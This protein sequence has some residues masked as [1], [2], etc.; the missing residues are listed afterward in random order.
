MS[1]RV[2]SAVALLLAAWPLYADD[3]TGA[4]TFLCS[5]VQATECKADGECSS[6]PPWN[7][8]FPQFLEIDLKKGLMATTQAS[9]ENRSTPILS[10][11]RAEGR[12]LLQG[13]QLGRAFSM[14][15]TEQTGVAA[16][17]IAAEGMTVTVFAACTPMTRR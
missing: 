3:L 11:E 15:V 17:A 16:I 13:M 7:W 1:T 9:G 4:D 2:G 10:K 6:G 8:K 12:I 5:A 14:V